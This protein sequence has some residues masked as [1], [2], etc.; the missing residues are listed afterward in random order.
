V[1]T[2]IYHPLNWRFSSLEY[3][4]LLI[5]NYSIRSAS[6]VLPP[7]SRESSKFAVLGLSIFKI[8]SSHGMCVV[9]V[10]NQGK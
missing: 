9:G 10:I 5:G 8:S 3:D 7:T 1:A 4:I 2:H 6:G